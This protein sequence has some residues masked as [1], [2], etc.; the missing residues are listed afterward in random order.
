MIQLLVN[1]DVPDLEAATKF[2]VDAF[3]LTVGRRMGS[4]FRELLGAAVPIYL[5]T[6]QAGSVPVPGVAARSFDRHWTPVHLDIAVPDL[7]AAL[8]RAVAAGARAE[9]GITAHAWGR[10]VLLSDP[11]GNGI[12]LLDLTPGYDAIVE[13]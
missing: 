3:G 9:S 13:R 7:E 2:Y 4:E 6:K 8:A 1:I 11:F 10:M 5:L 12:D